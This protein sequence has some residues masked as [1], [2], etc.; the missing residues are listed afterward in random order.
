MLYFVFK[1]NKS[2]RNLVPIQRTHFLYLAFVFPLL[3]LFKCD[4]QNTYSFVLFE[5]QVFRNPNFCFDFVMLHHFRQVILTQLT[6]SFQGSFVSEFFVL[7]VLNL[8]FWISG[9]V[10][11]CFLIEVVTKQRPCIVDSVCAFFGH[12]WNLASQFLLQK[13]FSKHLQLRNVSN[14]YRRIDSI[15]SFNKFVLPFF[16]HSFNLMKQ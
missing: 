2:H 13:P 14:L 12:F 3:Q 5:M 8:Y 6:T 1:Q 15:L 11:H 16:N 4:I 7:L 9:I 10:P